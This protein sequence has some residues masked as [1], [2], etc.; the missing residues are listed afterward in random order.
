MFEFS[1]AKS[2]LWPKKRHL[3]VSLIGFLS[4]FVISIVIWLLLLFLSITEGIEKTWLSKLTSLHA[5]IRITPKEAYYRSYYYQVDTIAAL[6]HYTP[7]TIGEKKISPISDPYQPDVDEEIP[8]Y[9]PQ[10]IYNKEGDPLDLV[11]EVFNALQS[12]K[13]TYPSL[14]F[15]D[16]EV[17]G[18]LARLR[19]L[20]HKKDGHFRECE[21]SFITQASYIA[22]FAEKN[23]RMPSLLQKPLVKDVNY[24]LTA[25]EYGFESTTEE[26]KDNP[27][28]SI[29]LPKS[30]ESLLSSI[31]SNL[32][33]DEVLLFEEWEMPHEFLPEEIP[34][35]AYASKNR[36]ISHFVLPT[37][38]KDAPPSSMQKGILKRVGKELIFTTPST[39]YTFTEEVPL[40]LAKETAVKAVIAKAESLNIEKLRDV[41][42][43]LSFSV[44]GQEIKGVCDGSKLAIHKGEL[45]YLFTTPPSIAPPWAYV[46]GNEIHL[47]KNGV[48][49]PKNFRDNHLLI[50]DGGYFAF[51]SPGG[52]F[53]QEERIPIHVAGFYDPG[54]MAMGARFL[55]APKEIVTLIH[56]ST[57]QTSLD[58]LLQNGIQV[59][60]KDVKK[61]KEL[62]EELTKIFEKENLSTYWQI[63]PFYEYDF[64]RDLIGQFQN[65]RILFMLI[66]IIILM[67]A[68]CNIISLLLLLVND[69]KHEI[70]VIISLGASK[71]SIAVIFGLC[72]AF[73]GWISCLVGI[74]CALLT[75]KNIDV[76]VRFLSMI[77]G[78][79][80]FNALFYGESLPKELSINALLFVLAVTPL[81]SLLAGLIPAMK[82]CKLKPSA[83]LRSE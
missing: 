21:Q 78:R 47:P 46:V 65:D 26:T 30:K 18:A 53:V 22:S 16:Y 2:Y 69:K 72:G 71:R 34:F 82:A 23:P 20:R 29:S 33:L 1:I 28:F 76:L 19:L 10:P 61:T 59:W 6:S 77:E 9:W 12:C 27:H 11:H 41:H 32:D 73:M 31:F 24:L 15:A 4:I 58:P 70:G 38:S 35:V 13:E 50:G 14:S 79:Q 17:T 74:G 3:A 52:S 42:F 66:G 48:L 8:F 83:I 7:K 45:R 55:L 67:V 54:I 68:C 5:P 75:L 51:N 56:A 64:A 49:L 37:N 44:Q 81:L 60:C 80:A 57:K 39:T 62:S 63:T 25:A 40:H 43:S 36:L